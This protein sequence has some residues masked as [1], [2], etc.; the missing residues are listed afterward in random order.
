[1]AWRKGP[2]NPKYRTPEHRA[3]VAEYNAQMARDGYLTCAETVCVMGSR[4]ILP[5]M[6]RA[7]GH[8]PNGMEYAGP[9]H[10]ECNTREA[11]VRAR[12]RQDTTPLRW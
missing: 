12:A 3:K 10:R 1:M 6:P 11:A 9:V 2:V 7:A 8:T 4:V 5:G